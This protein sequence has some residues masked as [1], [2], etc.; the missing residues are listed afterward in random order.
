MIS[1]SSVRGQPALDEHRDA[2]AADLAQQRVVLH[3]ARADLDDVGDLGDGLDVARVHQLGDDRQ[4]GA[5]P[6]PR[7]AGAGP[8][9]RGPGRR[10]ATCAACR[11]RRGTWLA[12]AASIASAVSS[13]WS[14]VSTVHGPAMRAKWSP[15]ILRAADLQ[16]RAGVALDLRR[17]QLVGLEDRDDLLD[18]LVALEAEAGDVLAV[19]DGADD[20]HLLA[21]AGVRAGRR[22]TRSARSRP[23][24]GPRW[25]SASSR[26]SSWCSF[27][28]LG[29]EV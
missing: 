25:P 3:V 18:A 27:C 12:P 28:V 15:P 9:G 21:A 13:V 14:R 10:R 5:L 19:A 16:D 29:V 24:P 22:R 1:S 17:G 26:S 23:A 6:W 20:R 8:P 2:G 7:R 4:A 11:R